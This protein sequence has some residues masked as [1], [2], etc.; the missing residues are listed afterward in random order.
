M[1]SRFHRIRAAYRTERATMSAGDARLYDATLSSIQDLLRQAR[2][3][4]LRDAKRGMDDF[5][6]NA[7]RG[8]EP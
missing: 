7:L 1:A 4:D 8:V 5:V 3:Q 6:K 2:P